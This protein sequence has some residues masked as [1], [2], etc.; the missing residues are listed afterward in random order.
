M[1][2]PNNQNF[3]SPLNFKFSLARAPTLNWNV[4]TVRV[5]GLSLSSGEMATPFVPLPTTGKITYQTLMVTF[6]VNEDLKDY[7]EIFNWMTGLGSP[8]DFSGYKSLSDNKKNNPGTTNQLTS[9]INLTIMNSS[10]L[11]NLKVDF[12]D[13]FPVDLSELQFNTMLTDVTYL[14]ATVEFR[15]LRY[16]IQTI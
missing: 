3:L 6:R 11:K 4:Q 7:L 10:K 13:A 1:A 5:P 16:T 8:T 15:F 14:E 9:D 2:Q 12:Y